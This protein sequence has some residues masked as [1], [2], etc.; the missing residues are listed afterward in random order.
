MEF[1]YL[2]IIMKAMLYCAVLLCSALCLS[3]NLSF[4]LP[5]FLCLINLKVF[6]HFLLYS[7]A[8]DL[9]IA[10]C[11]FLSSL[12]VFLYCQSEFL[13]KPLFS[14]SFAAH[15]Q[16]QLFELP[17][18]ISPT[19][20]QSLC[21][22]SFKS[23]KL[24]FEFFFQTEI[25]SS[26]NIC[27]IPITNTIHTALCFA[28]HKKFNLIVYTITNVPILDTWYC[29]LCLCYNGPVSTGSCHFGVGVSAVL[30]DLSQCV[31]WTVAM[32][33]SLP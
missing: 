12:I 24:L 18:I 22:V 9:C 32:I 4:C 6:V 21:V 20:L 1:S 5:H 23:G 15:S 26:C 11:Y 30:I 14:C 27:T 16:I 31:L 7:S 13:T 3:H 2:F 19:A 8:C 29:F 33:F 17:V 28:A 25:K 10:F